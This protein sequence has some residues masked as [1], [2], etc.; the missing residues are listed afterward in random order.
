MVTN[1]PLTRVPKRCRMEGCT[2]A[3]EGPALT[4]LNEGETFQWGVC[5]DCIAKA[6][7]R[8]RKVFTPLGKKR[9][10]LQ[11]GDY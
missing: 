11:D 4:P 1:Y 2:S 3:W 9:E 7:R 5:A 8:D 10:P 6:E